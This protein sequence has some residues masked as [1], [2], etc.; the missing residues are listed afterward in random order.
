MAKEKPQDP[1]DLEQAI[2]QHN[3]TDRFVNIRFFLE[4]IPI[5]LLSLGVFLR[6]KGMPYWDYTLLIGGVLSAGVYLLFSRFLLKAERQKTYEVVLSV[7]SGIV[8]PLGILGLVFDTM[9]W[10]NAEQ[11]MR[12]SLYGCLGL[13]FVTILSF[14]YRIKNQNAARFHRSLLSRLMIFAV[15]LYSVLV[16]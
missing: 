14:L 16:G 7:A 3:V 10:N 5:T 4:L 8:I 1:L 15:I 11:M 6:Y 2:G 12:Y 9:Y 13:V